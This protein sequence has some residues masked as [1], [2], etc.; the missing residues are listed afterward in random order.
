M[1][2]NLW[3]SDRPGERYWMEI[4]DRAVLGEDLYAPQYDGA[5]RAQWSYTL[6]TE[7]VPGDV[8]FHWHKHF[9]GEPALVGWSEVTGPLSVG[10]ITW[11][12]HGTRGRARAGA[13]TGPSWRMQ[14]GGFN[15]FDRPITLADLNGKESAIREI[16]DELHAEAKGSL[17]FPF[18]F[19]RPSEIRASQ[20]YLT[21]FPARLL[22]LFEQ[23]SSP[24][25]KVEVD[26]DTPERVRR[27]VGMPRTQ[28]PKL[29]DAIERHAV[30]RAKAHYVQ[31]G[32]TKIEELGKPYDL[33][34]YGLGAER[35][36]EVKGSSAQAVAVELTTN[37][38][39]H[40]R[41]YPHTDLIVVDEISWQPDGNGGYATSGGVLRTWESWRPDD[42]DLSPT[43]FRYDLRPQPSDP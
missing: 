23:L 20:A 13:T 14:C 7:T 34:V 16:Y 42:D 25:A 15:A 4:T 33:L 29:R 37:E 32:A 40:A 27:S 26:L 39:T 3:W 11:Q 24:R 35:H 5:G 10:S 17:Y 36:A 30:D 18:S 31:R 19:Y 21:K 12:A 41:N 38:V 1:A 22:T 6:V 2:L 8:V 28:D 9:A 43:K